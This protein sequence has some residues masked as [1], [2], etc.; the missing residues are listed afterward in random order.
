MYNAYR[1]RTL[2]WFRLTSVKPHGMEVL[3]HRRWRLS[4]KN[5][6]F[7]W[8]VFTESAYQLY[9]RPTLSCWR[10]SNSIWWRSWKIASGLHQC[11]PLAV[12]CEALHLNDLLLNTKQALSKTIKN[13]EARIFALATDVNTNAYTP[14]VSESLKLILQLTNAGVA[15]THRVLVTVKTALKCCH[16]TSTF[17]INV[18]L[19]A[20]KS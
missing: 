3:L 4:K 9:E 2:F 1:G 19:I 8:Y 7:S 14:K 17:T 18:K 12:P 11:H 6:V 15:S 10:R 13:I 20:V 5:S 16:L